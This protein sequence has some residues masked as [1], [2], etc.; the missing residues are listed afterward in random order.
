MNR[1]LFAALAASAALMASPASAAVTIGTDSGTRTLNTGDSVSLNFN[2]VS[3]GVVAGLT[4]NL[5]LTLTGQSAGQS[6]FSYILSN[7]SSSPITQSMVTAF[8]FD[9]DPAA[10]GVN[11]ITNLSGQFTGVGS[12][13]IANGRNV[14]LCFTADN[15]PQCNGAGSG[16]VGLAKGASTSGTFTLL[17]SGNDGNNVIL[18]DFA[19]RYQALAGVNANSATGAASIAAVPEPGTWALMLLGFGA[20]GFSMR[21]QRR[22][23]AMPQ[24]A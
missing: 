6:I 20:V 3:G 11:G 2:G 1:T 7:T 19:V 14:E 15:G 21:R 13:N 17:F 23:T 9:I 8:G 18:N 4:S 5:L 16:N 12:G 10:T 24:I 22:V